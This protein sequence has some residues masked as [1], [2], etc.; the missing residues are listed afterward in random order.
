[1][2]QGGSGWLFSSHN[3]LTAHIPVPARASREQGQ[4]P[5]VMHRPGNK[6]QVGTTWMSSTSPTLS[7]HLCHSVRELRM[8]TLAKLLFPEYFGKSLLFPH[9]TIVFPTSWILGGTTKSLNTTLRLGAWHTGSKEMAAACRLTQ[10]SHSGW[11]P[12][13]PSMAPQLPRHRPQSLSLRDREVSCTSQAKCAQGLL[14]P[15][16]VEGAVVVRLDALCV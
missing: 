9:T 15:S 12:A 10:H 2:C 7:T 11:A 16:A 6:L 13:S 4:I 8:T 14:S 5:T 1:M 3:A